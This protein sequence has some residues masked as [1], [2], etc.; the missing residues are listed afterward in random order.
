[1]QNVNFK[2]KMIILQF[3]MNYPI[4]DGQHTKILHEIGITSYYEHLFKLSF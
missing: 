2:F 4:S 3:A 1:M